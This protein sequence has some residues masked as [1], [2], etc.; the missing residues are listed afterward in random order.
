M[1]TKRHWCITPVGTAKDL[2]QKITQQSWALCTGFQLQGYLF[3]NDATSEDAA[4]EYAAIKVLPKRKYLEVKS[5]TFSWCTP[6]RALKLILQVL[7]GEFD[8]EAWVHLGVAGVK[9]AQSARPLLTM[10]VK[11]P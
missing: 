7:A 11:K 6:K 8:A 1:H 3:L 10:R 9:E 5:I 2:A 4:Q